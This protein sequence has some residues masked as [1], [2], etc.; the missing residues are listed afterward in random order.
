MIIKYRR[1][2]AL[3]LVSSMRRNGVNKIDFTIR[4]HTI[5]FVL[6]SSVS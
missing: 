3:R 1:Q 2:C 5:P 6:A 4:N